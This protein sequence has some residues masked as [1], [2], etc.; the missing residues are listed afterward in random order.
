MIYSHSIASG[1]NKYIYGTRALGR[2]HFGEDVEAAQ[3]WK[4]RD[5]EA[6]EEGDDFEHTP[7]Y[8]TVESHVAH[9]AEIHAQELAHQSSLPGVEKIGVQGACWHE[10]RSLQVEEVALVTLPGIGQ[11]T[12]ETCQA[13]EEDDVEVRVARLALVEPCEGV[14]RIVEK[15][16]V[17]LLAVEAVMEE[18]AEEER[19][20]RFH[21]MEGQLPPRTPESQL[22]RFL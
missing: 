19:H 12:Q 9:G 7:T 20:R 8:G 6:V 22:S 2:E 10:R 18:L 21:R 13:Q 16:L 17:L 11:E 15:G 5:V 1:L 3:W 14:D 4:L